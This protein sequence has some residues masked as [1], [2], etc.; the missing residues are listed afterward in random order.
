[1][2]DWTNVLTD[3]E[4]DTLFVVDGSIVPR[5]SVKV[6]VFGYCISPCW[7]VQ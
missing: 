5:V 2:G 3:G 1:M 6:M 7:P 4:G